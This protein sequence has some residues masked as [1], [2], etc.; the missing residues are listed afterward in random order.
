[1]WV[2]KSLFLTNTTNCIEILSLILE[3]APDKVKTTCRVF[4]DLKGLMRRKMISPSLERSGM[5]KDLL[6][7]QLAW[8]HQHRQLQ[9]RQ[10]FLPHQLESYH[11]RNTFYTLYNNPVLRSRSWSK[12]ACPFLSKAYEVKSLFYKTNFFLYT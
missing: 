8:Q 9:N 11:R 7:E 1:M 2:R 12:P 4:S 3:T 5:V 10:G 6:A